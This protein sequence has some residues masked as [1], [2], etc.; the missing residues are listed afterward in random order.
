MSA[1]GAPPGIEMP[2]TREQ[3]TAS[4]EVSPVE[5]GLGP[6]ERGQPEEAGHEQE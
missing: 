3:E 2:E 5:D 6:H 4:D 1:A